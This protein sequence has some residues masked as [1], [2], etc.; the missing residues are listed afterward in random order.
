MNAA[1]AYPDGNQP[2]RRNLPPI[3]QTHSGSSVCP[4]FDLCLKHRLEGVLLPRGQ[5]VL[6][7]FA[8]KSKQPELR[9][10]EPPVVDDPNPAAFAFRATRILKPDL[11]QSACCLDDVTSQWILEQEFLKC[12]EYRIIPV[13][14]PVTLKGRQVARRRVLS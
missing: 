9:P 13:A 7:I 14:R 1:Y 8:V 4:H 6:D 12:C 11:T 2:E 10:F 3:H 5:V